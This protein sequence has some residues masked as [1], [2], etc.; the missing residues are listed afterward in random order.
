MYRQVAIDGQE[1][2]FYMDQDKHIYDTNFV[3]IGEATDDS[4]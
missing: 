2:L 1:G 4:D 3:N